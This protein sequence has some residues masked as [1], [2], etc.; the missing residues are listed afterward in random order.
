ME[1][2]SG[3]SYIIPL[4]LRFKK[5]QKNK[6][7][8]LFVVSTPVVC[9]GAVSETGGVTGPTLR[10]ERKRSTR[11][12][13]GLSLLS[14]RLQVHPMGGNLRG[15]NTTAGKKNNFSVSQFPFFVTYLRSRRDSA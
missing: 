9:S 13:W 4:I 1:S 5:K 3:E 14:R 11:F 10:T 7:R 8:H 12:I 6:I 2:L 15:G